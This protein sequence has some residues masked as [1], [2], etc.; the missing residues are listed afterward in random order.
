MSSQRIEGGKIRCAG[1]RISKPK[2]VHQTGKHRAIE[3]SVEGF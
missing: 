3:I 2:L 1:R